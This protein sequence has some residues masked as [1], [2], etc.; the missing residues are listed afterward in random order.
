MAMHWL[1]EGVQS[2]D[3]LVFLYSGHGL[4][5]RNYTYN[6][7]DHH[8]ENLCLLD[9][10]TQGMIVDDELNATLVGHLPRGANLHAII[11]ACHSGTILDLP[12]FFCRMD[13]NVSLK[14][15]SIKGNV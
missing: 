11:K 14:I 15:F 3:S 7:T 10:K 12:Y 8:D 9:F 4:Q 6:E 2:G 1:M 13:L 5:Q